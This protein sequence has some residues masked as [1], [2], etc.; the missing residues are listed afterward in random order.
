[1]D[2]M[3]AQPEAVFAIKGNFTIALTFR[4]RNQ[5]RVL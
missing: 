4:T 5:Q 2:F 1:M 3:E